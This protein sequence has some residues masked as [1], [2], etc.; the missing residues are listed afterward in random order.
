MFSQTVEYAL[1][2]AVTLASIPGRRWT[3][4]EIAETSRAPLH[5]LSKILQSLAKAGLVA[6]V[7]GLHGGYVLTRAPEDISVLDVVTAIEPIPRVRRCPLGLKEHA[8]GLCPLHR[9]LDEAAASVEASMRAT[10]LAELVHEPG[11]SSPLCL[12]AEA[13]AVWRS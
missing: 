7:R 3:V 8:S 4:R 13:G 1:R 2:A 10:S 5:Y 12:R 9:R 6:S 11:P